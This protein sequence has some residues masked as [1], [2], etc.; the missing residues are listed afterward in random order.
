MEH[1]IRATLNASNDAKNPDQDS[2]LLL[3]F[4]DVNKEKMGKIIAEN[5]E[6]KAKNDKIW[7]IAALGIGILIICFLVMA[8]I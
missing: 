4:T 6:I 2:E 3:Y 7:D 1:K 5:E 8:T